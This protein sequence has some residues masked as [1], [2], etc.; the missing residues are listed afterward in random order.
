M[1]PAVLKHGEK[2]AMCLK[3]TNYYYKPKTIYLPSQ[4]NVK[5][6]SAGLLI[7]HMSDYS[8]NLK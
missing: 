3:I 7:P 2:K 6:D 4:R 5:R 1:L 8:L